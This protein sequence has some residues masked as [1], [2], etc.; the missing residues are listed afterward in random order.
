MVGFAYRIYTE[1]SQKQTRR[2][3]IFWLSDFVFSHYR[4][5]PHDLLV[6]KDCKQV[7][8]IFLIYMPGYSRLTLQLL[9][10][11]VVLILVEI[12]KLLGNGIRSRLIIGVMV[13][14][15]VRVLEGFFNSNTLHRVESQ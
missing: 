4:R 5:S 10:G 7:S 6:D 1:K 15:E 3:V 9:L 11:K 2:E 12:E 8:V 14:L 13:W